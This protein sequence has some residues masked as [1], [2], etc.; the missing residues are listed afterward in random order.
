MQIHLTAPQRFAADL[1]LQ[2]VNETH[3][4]LSWHWM[5]QDQCE[6]VIGAKVSGRV[7][8]LKN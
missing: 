5:G 3:L 1:K 4:N 6:N 8:S 7:W 2:I